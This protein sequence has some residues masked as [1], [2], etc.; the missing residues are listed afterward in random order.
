MSEFVLVGQ[1]SHDDSKQFMN[2]MTLSM[3]SLM[4]VPNNL[5]KLFDKGLQV[6]PESHRSSL[7]KSMGRMISCL[8]IHLFILAEP[9]A[10]SMENTYVYVL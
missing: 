3:D 7:L 10:I 8:H 5:I 9:C 1:N 6:S 4:I 2:F